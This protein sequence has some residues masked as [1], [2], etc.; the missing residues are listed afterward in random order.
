MSPF[1]LILDELLEAAGRP[2][3]P[4]FCVSRLDVTYGTGCSS[5]TQESRSTLITPIP[6]TSSVGLWMKESEEQKG[7]EVERVV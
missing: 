1:V 5:A 7:G 6:A 4:L 2:H 3:F